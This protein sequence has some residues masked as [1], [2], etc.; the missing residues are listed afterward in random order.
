[1]SGLPSHLIHLDFNTLFVATSNTASAL[2]LGD[3]VVDQ[4]NTLSSQGAHAYNASINQEVMIMAIPLCFVGDSPM[5]AEISN[6]CNPASTLTPC[7]MC[8]LS[9]SS[10]GDK[11]T[12]R[13]IQQFLGVSSGGVRTSPIAR[14]W[15]DTIVKTHQLWHMS[16]QPGTF[17]KVEDM[18]KAFGIKDCMNQSFIDCLKDCHRQNPH[19][20]QAPRQLAE[21]WDHKYGHRMFNPF[22]R[23]RGFDGHKDTPVEALHVVLLG[24]TKYL[25]RDCIAK[26]S[27]K[28]KDEVET[29][30]KYFNTTGLGQDHVQARRMVVHAQSLNGKEFRMVLQGALFV[31]CRL[32]TPLYRAVW[33]HLGHIATMVYQ[34]E[35]RNMDAYCTEL[36]NTIELFLLCVTKLTAQ[37]LNKPK[38]HMFKH[39]TQ[40]I[41]RFGPASLF[42]PES[43]ERQNGVTRKYSIHS[44]RHNPTFDIAN[45]ANSYHGLK[46]IL[47]AGLIRHPTRREWLPPGPRILEFL[48]NNHRLCSALGYKA[49]HKE[50]TQDMSKSRPQEIAG[51]E[52]AHEV[53]NDDRYHLK[54]ETRMPL[55]S[56]QVACDTNFVSLRYHGGDGTIRV[57]QVIDMWTATPRSGSKRFLLRVSK[58][59]PSPTY[60]SFYGMREFQV[61]PDTRWFYVLE[62]VCLI[63]AQH[64]CAQA[65]CSIQEAITNYMEDN[66]I[67]KADRTLVHKDHSS[68]IVNASSLYYGEVH[69]HLGLPRITLATPTERI[70]A[71]SDGL[72]V[73]KAAA[74]A[75]KRTSGPVQRGNAGVYQGHTQR[76]SIY[77][78]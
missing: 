77:S 43:F 21:F 54:Q 45:T 17:Q 13:Y 16:R 64:N 4:L 57:G 35:I 78:L 2:E 27:D 42:A 47:S 51:G 19:Y 30:W 14:C 74:A 28:Q 23:L 15:D 69:R 56:G 6:T 1:M 3:H 31:F 22:L 9:A 33:C 65:E 32:I 73:W 10:M 44:N 66:I 20:P 41:R 24:A 7:R 61:L 26:L 52:S 11:K 50:F 55:P 49:L 48:V 63:N 18:G 58:C 46:H 29:R 40:C 76:N 62:A 67:A 72:A 12:A 38:F 25:Y 39:F 8:P 68:Y 70:Q 71:I 37:W 59:V 75:L 5:H 34:H 53:A 60:N 36:D